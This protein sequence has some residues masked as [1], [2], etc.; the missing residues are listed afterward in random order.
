M[1]VASS[2]KAPFSRQTF[3]SRDR[4]HGMTATPSSLPVRVKLP[5]KTVSDLVP[6]TTRYDI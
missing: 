3:Q 6:Q 5:V 4:R 1:T 2:V